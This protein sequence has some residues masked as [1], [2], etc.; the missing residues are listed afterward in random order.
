MNA[1]DFSAY[2]FRHHPW[3]AVMATN[4]RA[5]SGLVLTGA[6]FA[7]CIST[8]AMCS[9]YGHL[10]A[11]VLHSRSQGPSRELRRY[12]LTVFV[13]PWWV[14]ALDGELRINPAKTLVSA[15]PAM[16]QHTRRQLLLCDAR[17][18]RAVKASARGDTSSRLRGAGSVRLGVLVTS[19]GRELGVERVDVVVVGARLAGRA[20][21]APLARAGRSVL[22]LDKMRFPSDQL[23][24]HVLLLAGPVS[25]QSSAPYR[26]FSV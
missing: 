1:R 9:C 22:V 23:S 3:T 11:P 4:A 10:G 25:W 14:P 21:A 15:E 2:A 26:G 20:V 5:C 8:S 12:V 13:R 19:T 7:I 17:E 24:T 18:S 16:R 6:T